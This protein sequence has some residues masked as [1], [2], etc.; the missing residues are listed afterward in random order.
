MRGFIRLRTTDPGFEPAGVLT[1]RISLLERDY[2]D[3]VVIGE[4]HERLLERLRSLPGVR[5]AAATTVVPL[6]GGTATYYW[7]GGEPVERTHDV[8][9]RSSGR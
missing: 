3:S 1:A 5:T 7:I 4:F 8:P 6:R 2:P 9:P